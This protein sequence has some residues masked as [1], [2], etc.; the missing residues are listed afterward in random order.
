VEY[1]HSQTFLMALRSTLLQ[2]NPVG[3]AVWHRFMKII[4]ITNT[5]VRLPVFEALGYRFRRR[6][7]FLHHA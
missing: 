1:L 2:T 5:T 6:R 3:V 7:F 4:A